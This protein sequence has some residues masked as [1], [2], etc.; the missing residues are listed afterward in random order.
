MLLEREN[1]PLRQGGMQIY[2]QKYRDAW[3]G[4]FK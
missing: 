4:A 3:M 1:L 2:T